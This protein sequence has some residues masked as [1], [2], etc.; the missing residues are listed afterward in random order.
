M[1]TRMYNLWPHMNELEGE[2]L[3]STKSICT[4]IRAL[5]RFYQ[6]L[7]YELRI[8]AFRML[9]L[10]FR[11]SGKYLANRTVQFS[12]FEQYFCMQSRTSFL[13]CRIVITRNCFFPVSGFGNESYSFILG[14]LFCIA[15][16]EQ[17]IKIILMFDLYG[18]L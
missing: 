4:C 3:M 6:N 7:V 10:S 16:R 5:Y 11:D 9:D 13:F 12:S 1:T 15:C 17:Y 8:D 14:M 2:L 18:K